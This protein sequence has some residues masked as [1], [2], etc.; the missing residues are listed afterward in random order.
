MY[1]AL[2]MLVCTYIKKP[3]LGEGVEALIVEEGVT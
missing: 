1:S 3:S 2:V